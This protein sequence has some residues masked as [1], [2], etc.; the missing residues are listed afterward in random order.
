[1]ICVHRNKEYF[2]LLKIKFSCACFSLLQERFY[3]SILS[4]YCQNFNLK[5]CITDT[6]YR[7]PAVFRNLISDVKLPQRPNFCFWR[8]D[9]REKTAASSLLFD[10]AQF[11]WAASDSGELL[12]ARN[13]CFSISRNEYS[14]NF[15][16]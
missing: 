15:H 6:T 9:Y 8:A 16:S 7:C 11:Y 14:L 10:R 4:T 1:M 3:L 13:T 5:T 2:L 12:H